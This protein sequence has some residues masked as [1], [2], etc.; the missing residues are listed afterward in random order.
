MTQVPKGIIDKDRDP[1][2]LLV[3]L[4]EAQDKAG[5]L[6]EEVMA[7][8]A[9]SLSISRSEVYGVATFYSFLSTKPLG[10]NVIRI[11][12][13]LPCY[14]KNYQTIVESIEKE[15]GIRPGQT[16]DDDRFTFTLTNC[17]GACDKAPA[18]LINS[19]VHAN[20]TPEKISQ[21][22]KDYK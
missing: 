11:C 2:Q 15:I 18:M 22:L 13:S 5:Y 9:E 14:L 20:L 17:I 16:T 12:Q 10:R 7:E 19:D 8:L 6:S 21:I 4:K 1:E 3:L